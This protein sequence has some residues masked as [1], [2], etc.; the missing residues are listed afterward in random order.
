MINPYVIIDGNK[1]AVVTGSYSRQW[2][3]SF[4]SYLSSNVVRLNFIDKGPGVRT[5]SMQLYLAPWSTT[6][7]PG[8]N[9]VNTTPEL[10]MAQLEVTYSKVATTIIFIDPFNEPP[11]FKGPIQSSISAGTT[12]IPVTAN[13]IRQMNTIAVPCTGYLWPAGTALGT[14]IANGTA[15]IITINIVGVSTLSVTRGSNPQAFNSG[16]NIAA[17]IGVYMTDL[18][19]VIPAY[20]TAQSSY[21]IATV[22]LTESTQSV[23]G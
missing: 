11:T 14:S 6:S 22:Q 20:G 23:L 9:G 10:Q 4:T 5:Y 17:K 13:M 21:I 8:L 19:Q 1:Y 15:E 2:I 16:D 7:I 18:Q 12:S 3:R